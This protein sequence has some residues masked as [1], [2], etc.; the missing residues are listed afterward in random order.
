VS[1]K[2]SCKNSDTAVVDLELLRC[3]ELIEHNSVY[4]SEAPQAPRAH[5]YI[6]S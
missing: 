2:Q 4:N 5:D 1:Q 3:L 6:A